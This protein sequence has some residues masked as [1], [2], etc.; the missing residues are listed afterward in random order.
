MA[1]A[2][3][4]YSVGTATPQAHTCSGSDRCLAVEVISTNNPTDVT[5]NGVSM[6]AANYSGTVFGGIRRNIYVLKNPASGANNIVVTGSIG[7]LYL[8]IAC[9]ATGIDQTT[10]IRTN[11]ALVN[12]TGNTTISAAVTSESGDLVIDWLIFDATADPVTT[13]GD[14]NHTNRYYEAGGVA[15]GTTI[16]NDTSTTVTYTWDG[17]DDA[18]V[19]TLALIPAS[20]GGGGVPI[21]ALTFFAEAMA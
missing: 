17:N 6:G 5:Y 4:A 15:L 8:I 20:G 16:A 21:A 7:T 9:S 18:S 14:A 13:A 2:F 1:A 3:D 19:V 10:T 12:V 11:G